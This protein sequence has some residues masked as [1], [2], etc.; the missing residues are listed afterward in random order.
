MFFCEITPEFMIQIAM[1]HANIRYPQSFGK[2]PD[3]VV[4]LF[5]IDKIYVADLQKVE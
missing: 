4:V 5:G 1:D 3:R 2:Y